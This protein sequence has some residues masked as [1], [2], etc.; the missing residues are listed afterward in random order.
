M[1]QK[2]QNHVMTSTNIE[3]LFLC[4]VVHVDDS[5]PIR[6]L[7]A[8]KRQRIVKRDQT[9]LNRMVKLFWKESC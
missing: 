3:L 1:L 7:V 6:I 5:R 8:N 4:F 2:T 9:S